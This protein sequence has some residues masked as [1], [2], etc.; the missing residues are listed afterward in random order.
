[1]SL[2]GQDGWLAL[3]PGVSLKRLEAPFLYHAG[4]DELF[5]L[6]EAG[7]K[8]LARCDGGITVEGAAL[9][10]DFLRYCLDE[11]LLTLSP[12]PDHLPVFVSRPSPV[13]SLRYLELQIT[14][15]CNLACAHCYLG[16]AKP[17]DMEVETIIRVAGEFE[18]IGGLR[19][20]V[21]GGE[22]TLHP[23]WGEVC[24]ALASVGVRKV[25]LTNG[26]PLLGM[27]I[28]SLGFNEIQVSIDG[29]E[30]GHEL[31]RGGGTFGKAVKA[32]KRIAGAGVALS[33]ATQVHSGNLAEMEE[34]ETL[35]RS[36]GA[37]EWGIDAPCVSGRLTV[38]SSLSVKPEEAVNAM[39]RAYGGSYH[40]GSG[41]AACG[42][43]LAT[44]GADGTVAQCGFY[45]DRPLG[46]VA[47][48]LET[49]WKLRAPL[50]LAEVA[51][52][53]GCD[54][55]EECGG[56]CR[57]RAGGKTVRDPVMCAAYGK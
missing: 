41:G 43:H 56:G 42:L 28:A 50:M 39:A 1:M 47:E 24:R 36:L 12:E 55:A 16:D 15:R 22:P 21:S 57:Y 26:I 25:L 48:G 32:A 37:R 8:A 7:F 31:L 18:R 29:M 51:E 53:A 2:Q 5:E 4:R 54:V 20:M 52:C 19:L 40:G 14:R 34:L 6:D 30:A 13:P 10:P 23:R 44:V 35:V 49:C 46:D 17:L 3:S 45:F 33:V 38:G 9:D 11:G 27:D